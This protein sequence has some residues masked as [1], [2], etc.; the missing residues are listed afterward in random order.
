[1]RARRR[2]DRRARHARGARRAR[3]H[4]RAHPPP[5]AAR[6]RDRGR[7][8][9]TPGFHDEEVM[10]K[11]YDAQLMRRLTPYFAGQ[12]HLVFL[13]F[14]LI[15][16]RMALEALPDT[17]MGYA[18]NRLTNVDSV[19]GFPSLRPLF[20][21]PEGIDWFWWVGGIYF[22]LAVFSSLVELARSVSMA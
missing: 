20:Q 6:G 1:P 7:R 4:L 17:I 14:A 2:Q 9:V 18:F 21:A 12:W 15:L 19:P 5:A 11:V 22:V 8:R 10:G 3:R 13:A 16:P